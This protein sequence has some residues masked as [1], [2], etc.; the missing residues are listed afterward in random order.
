MFRDDLLQPQLT[1]AIGGDLCAQVA[2][3]LVGCAHV[4]QN[5][6]QR[7]VLHG[8]SSHQVDRRNTQALLVD[9]RRQRHAAGAHA[10]DV[11][12]VGAVRNVESRLLCGVEDPGDERDVRQV[13]AALERIVEHDDVAR[14]ELRLLQSPLDRHGHGAQ[15]HGDVVALGQHPPRNVED[16]SR[17]IA[18]LFDVR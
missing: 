13:R 8:S 9:F 5:E 14:L 10:A 18:A 1:D 11:G 16:R 15:V 6:A 7:V 4:R 2:A 3:A 17:K 12:M